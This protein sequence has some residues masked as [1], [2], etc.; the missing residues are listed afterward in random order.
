MPRHVCLQF[1]S[2]GLRIPSA[3]ASAAPSSCLVM[4]F[5]PGAIGSRIDLQPLRD[6]A[7]LKFAASAIHGEGYR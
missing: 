1:L 5:E 4:R 6:R 2:P 7:R 3:A